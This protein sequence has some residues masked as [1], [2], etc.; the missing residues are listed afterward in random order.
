MERV[1]KVILDEKTYE[2][3]EK[4][5]LTKGKTISEIAYEKLKQALTPPQVKTQKT[6]SVD[7]S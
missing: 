3:L 5:A 2:L 6:Q 7:K 4:Q 1:I